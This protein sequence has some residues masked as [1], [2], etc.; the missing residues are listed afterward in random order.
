MCSNLLSLLKSAFPEAMFVGRLTD[1]ALRKSF[2]WSLCGGERRLSPKRV[3]HHWP[4]SIM[5]S[6]SKGITDDEDKRTKAVR[7]TRKQK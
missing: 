2:Q 5:I 1:M 7:Q 3:D 4:K 6:I